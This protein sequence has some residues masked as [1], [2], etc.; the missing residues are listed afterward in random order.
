MGD[1]APDYPGEF[2]ETIMRIF[3]ALL[4]AALV[5]ASGPALARGSGSFAGA[6]VGHGGGAP[7]PLI[8]ATQ[9]ALQAPGSRDYYPG[10]F[11]TFMHWLHGDGS[12]SADA[13]RPHVAVQPQSKP[14]G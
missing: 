4:A 6:G 8:N 9:R 5:A 12:G 14:N 3:V 10:P 11:G 1:F 2:Q 13:A 7:Q